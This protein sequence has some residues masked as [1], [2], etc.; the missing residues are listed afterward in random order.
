MLGLTYR[1]ELDPL[2]VAEFDS[3]IPR[4]LGAARANSK[5]ENL[6][7]Y[8]SWTAL[9]TPSQVT[10]SNGTL[11]VAATEWGPARYWKLRDTLM[12]NVSVYNLV[13]GA[14][15]TTLD[16][17]LPAG[18]KGRLAVSRFDIINTKSAVAFVGCVGQWT[19]TAGATGAL[20]GRISANGKQLQ[21][22][23]DDQLTSFP[24]STLTFH[25]QAIIPIEVTESS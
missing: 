15:T 19:S 23:Y 11:V 5:L 4:I 18:I 7:D 20:L 25:I 6:T 13:P 24:N 8:T 14:T 17:P 1:D 10:M 21:C 9:D 2:L 16:L 3:L 22:L 12:L